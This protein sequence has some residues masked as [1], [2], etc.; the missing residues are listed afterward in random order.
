MENL[1]DVLPTLEELNSEEAKNHFW[2]ICVLC[3]FLMVLGVVG[4]LHVIIILGFRMKPSNH[5]IFI[6]YLGLLDMT[7]CCFCNARGF[8]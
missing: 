3:Q 8:W 4:N 6:L 5:R 1:S 2:W 7:I